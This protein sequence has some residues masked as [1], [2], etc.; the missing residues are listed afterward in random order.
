[1]SCDKHF[2]NLEWERHDW[3]RRVSATETHT[4]RQSDMWGRQ[5]LGEYATCHAVYVCRACG[6]TRDGEECGC[7]KARADSCAV[8]LAYL[9]AS[10]EPLVAAAR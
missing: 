1:M 10:T 9:E 8:R 3:V 5:V 2:L 4:S 6:K 7:D